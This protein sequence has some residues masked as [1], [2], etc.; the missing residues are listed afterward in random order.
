M[1]IEGS[2]YRQ[3]IESML[4]KCLDKEQARLV[5]G[6]V[7]EGL[8]GM[9]QSSHKMRW[10]LRRV[11]C[12]WPTTM[13]DCIRYKKGCESCQKFGDVQLAP[14]SVLH[15][16][17]KPWPFRG[18]GLDFVGQIQPSSSKGHK[19]VLVAMN[20]FSKWTATMLLKNMTHKEVISFILEHI[21]YLFG[22]P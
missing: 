11:G 17:I 16:V 15:P 2:L 20:Y 10:T 8:C 4:L 3:T 19:F 22:I 14:A 12:Y 6:E 9:N 1:M 13:S 7:D 21:V 18:S 5:M